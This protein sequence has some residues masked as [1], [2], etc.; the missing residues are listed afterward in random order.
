M[1]PRCTRS[2]N[3]GEFSSAVHTAWRMREELLGLQRPS[4]WGP[5]GR[6]G[7]R[8]GGGGV[9]PGVVGVGLPVG[10]VTACRV[11]R[12]NNRCYAMGP[13]VR[14]TEATSQSSQRTRTRGGDWLHRA[15]R[16]VGVNG[17]PARGSRYGKVSMLGEPY[18]HRNDE[19]RLRHEQARQ[20][21]RHEQARQEP[22]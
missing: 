7:Q 22:Q 21:P 2:S 11:R 8:R 15:G 1:P 4:V 19:Q 20:Q 5:G 16:P 17:G 14:R 12:D 9:K 6:K 18:A 3:S 10:R 13:I